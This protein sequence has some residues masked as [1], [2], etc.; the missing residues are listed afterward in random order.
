MIRRS[1]LRVDLDSMQFLR[2]YDFIGMIERASFVIAVL[3][4]I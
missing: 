4:D 2:F 1:C 3:I